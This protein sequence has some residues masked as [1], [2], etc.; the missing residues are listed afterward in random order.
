ME[1]R[2]LENM[3]NEE[4]SMEENKN[5]KK[6]GIV[7]GV[8]IAVI[9]IGFAALIFFQK[10]SLPG[11]KNN[12]FKKKL[13][14]EIDDQIE[15]GKYTGFTYEITQKMWDEAVAEENTYYETVK[16]AAK[17]GDQVDFH[18]IGYVNGK[19]DDNI[20]ET[21][22]EVVIGNDAEGVYKKIE[23]AMIGHKAKEIVKVEVTG[24]EAATLAKDASVDY[25]AYE[26]VTFEIKIRTVSGQVIEE[27]TN[28]WVK[29]NYQEEYG[30]TTTEEFYDYIES[31]LEEQATA[32]IWQMA[33]D[34]ATMKAYPQKVYDSVVEEF[35]NDAYYE[36]D[37]WGMSLEDYLY[38][39][40]MYT[41][42][43]L[44]QE[45]LNEVKS[46]LVMWAIAKE[47]GFEISKEE[48]AEEYDSLY[49]SLGYSSVEEMKELYTDNDMEEA[50]MLEKVQGHVMDGSTIKKSFER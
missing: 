47:E 42:E 29:D 49:E 20:S 50:A 40:C 21:D 15:L 8:I 4:P 36:A 24:E 44:E 41:E 25:T 26:T 32:E 35:Q 28:E 37:Q 1:N 22:L 16:R 11:S 19:K 43:S 18:Y 34:A 27:I 2:E 13:G 14:Y 23:D 30:Y 38:N 6:G 7:V 48:I 31:Y 17:E 39:F 33:L 3:N 46:E 12:D 10:T 5:G 45:Y 9:L